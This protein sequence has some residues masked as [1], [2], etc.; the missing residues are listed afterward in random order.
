M[1]WAFVIVLVLLIPILAIVIDSQVGQAL[2]ARISK[3]VPGGEGE[4]AARLEVLE[5]D[6]RYLSESM[7]SLREESEFVRSLIEGGSSI[8]LGPGAEEASSDGDA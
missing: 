1:V 2:A 5:A 3:S 7:E 8:S 6:V 4:L